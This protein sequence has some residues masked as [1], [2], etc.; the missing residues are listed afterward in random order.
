M[1]HRRETYRTLQRDRE[2]LRVRFHRCGMKC[3]VESLWSRYFCFDDGLG[4]GFVVFVGRGVER[5]VG[6]R[7][8]DQV[9][10]LCFEFFYPPFH[11]VVFVLETPVFF[12]QGLKLAFLAI[13]RFLGRSAIAHGAFIGTGFFFLFCPSF[14]LCFFG[15]GFCGG[16]CGRGWRPFDHYVGEDQL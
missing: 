12:L 4:T 1:R 11:F 8:Y 6:Y 2:T 15:S 3:Q 16:R 7:V 14:S 9:E 5:R 13:T 10:L